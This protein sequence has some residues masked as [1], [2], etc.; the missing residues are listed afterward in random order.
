MPL[1]T[2]RRTNPINIRATGYR[3]INKMSINFSG[4]FTI[5]K[6]TINII[7][8]KRISDFINRPSFH[9]FRNEY[10]PKLYSNEKNKYIVLLYIRSLIIKNL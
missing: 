1:I 7:M 6:P 2:K 8:G 4:L 5:N 10:G 3:D 9:F